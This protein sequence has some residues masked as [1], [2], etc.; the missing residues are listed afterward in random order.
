MIETMR[1]LG[2]TLS[3]TITG[4]VFAVFL[5]NA[6]IT[7]SLFPMFMQS[8]NRSFMIFLG[9]SVLCLVIIRTLKRSREARSL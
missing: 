8:F 9:I 5:G 3:I 7:P 4:I 2:M 1:L 6:R